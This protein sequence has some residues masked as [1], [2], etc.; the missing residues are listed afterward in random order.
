MRYAAGYTWT[1]GSTVLLSDSLGL[2]NTIQNNS[3]ASV[4][5]KVDLMRLYNKVK[6]LKAINEA[7]P[8]AAAGARPPQPAAPGAAAQDTTEKKPELK[9]LKATL[10]ILMAVQSVNFTYQL[11]RGNLVPGYLPKSKF[12]GFDEGFNAPGLPFILGKQFE[13]SELYDLMDRNGWY[14]N[15]SHL[16]NT[17]FSGLRTENFSARTN[18]VPFKNFNVQVEARRERSDIEEAFYRL[19]VDEATGNPVSNV[20]EL[21]NPYHTG[22]FSTSILTLGTLFEGNRGNQSQAFDNFIKY[23]SE[24]APRLAAANPDKSGTYT[25]NSQD[26]LIPAF[27]YAYTGKDISSY[28]PTKKAS[29]STNLFKSIPIPNWRVGS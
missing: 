21:Q 15:N 18:V 26:V 6:F 20:E 7:A 19:S 27:M 24:I 9:A 13:L 4:T 14:T 5:G 22:S 16:L 10:K 28:D 25:K 3:D 1:S 12:L 11:T 8:T 23:R 29:R 2:G 17:A